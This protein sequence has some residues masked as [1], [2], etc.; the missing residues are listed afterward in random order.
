MMNKN[1]NPA[2]RSFKLLRRK[3]PKTRF[4]FKGVRVSKLISK[5]AHD[6]FGY[7]TKK[8]SLARFLVNFKTLALKAQK[9]QAIKKLI[10]LKTYRG[11][12]HEQ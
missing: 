5:I 3:R 9:H 6:K 2:L 10:Y 7:I 1:L 4:F 12:R 8:R 11:N